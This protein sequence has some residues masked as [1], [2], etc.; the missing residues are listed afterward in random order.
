MATDL[1]HIKKIENLESFRAFVNMDHG[2][3]MDYTNLGEVNLLGH[4]TRGRRIK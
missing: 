2:I 4:W 3:V 1:D